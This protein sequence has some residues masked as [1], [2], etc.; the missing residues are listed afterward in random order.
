MNRSCLVV[1]HPISDQAP[2]PLCE[3]L[4][5]L[6]FAFDGQSFAQVRRSYHE[7][8]DR[9]RSCHHAPLD[10]LDDDDVTFSITRRTH[11]RARSTT[12]GARV[13][14]PSPRAPVITATAG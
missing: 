9:E 2:A 6:A 5:D 8:R 4:D 13:T 1:H 12:T 10:R 11:Q 7:R 14:S 3:L